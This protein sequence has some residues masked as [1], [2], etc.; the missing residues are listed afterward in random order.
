MK[1]YAIVKVKI[2]SDHFPF[3]YDSHRYGLHFKIFGPSAFNE[4]CGAYSFDSAEHCERI[5]RER[6]VANKTKY[7]IVRIVEA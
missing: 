1:K 4:V 2:V 6:L 7:E 5:L 3:R